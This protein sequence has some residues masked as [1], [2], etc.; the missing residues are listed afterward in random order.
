MGTSIKSYPIAIGETNT[1][2]S[3][4]LFDFIENITL[5]KAQCWKQQI[6]LLILSIIMYQN[7]EIFRSWK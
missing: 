2:F 5:K 7:V 3:F 1:Y 6:I 4:N